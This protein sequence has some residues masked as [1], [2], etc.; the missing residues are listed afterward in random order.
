MSVLEWNESLAIDHDV[1]DDTHKAFVDLLNRLG[2][3][4]DDRV[5]GVI[6]EFIEHTVEHFA[7]EER[8][9]TDLT[10]PPL[11]CHTNEHQ[12]VLEIAR[13]VRTRVANGEARFGKVL[14]QAVAEWFENHAASMDTV[15]SMY[16][17]EHGYTP[18]VGA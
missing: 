7:Q 18:T 16:M 3:A 14:A 1:M 13:E 12:G 6:D 11:H 5:L 9:M 17:K 15:L 4:P 10:F 2:E 8:W